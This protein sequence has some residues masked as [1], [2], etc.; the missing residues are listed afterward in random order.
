LL[1]QEIRAMNSTSTTTI[2]TTSANS[3]ERQGGCTD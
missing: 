1:G 3:P 2:S